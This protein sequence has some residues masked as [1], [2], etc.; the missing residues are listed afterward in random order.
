MSY[1]SLLHYLTLIS[2]SL[3]L[4]SLP[5]WSYWDCPD[6]PN[7]GTCVEK[8]GPAPWEQFTPGTAGYPQGKRIQTRYSALQI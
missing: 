7:T 5:A 2:L 8:P 3:L 6:Y 4:L 1:R